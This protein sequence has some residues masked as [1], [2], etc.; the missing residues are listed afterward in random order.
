L[1]DSTFHAYGPTERDTHDILQFIFQLLVDFGVSTTPAAYI[2]SITVADGAACPHSTVFRL[3]GLN[4]RGLPIKF[5][6]EK[7]RHQ[8]GYEEHHPECDQASP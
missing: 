8:G 1:P 3:C 7:A 5:Q 4:V 2:E 6:E